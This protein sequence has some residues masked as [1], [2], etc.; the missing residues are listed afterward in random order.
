MSC[1]VDTKCFDVQL[2]L[3]LL[4]DNFQ[5]Y[6][7]SARTKAGKILNNVVTHLKIT[8]PQYFGVKVQDRMLNWVIHS[9]M[10]PTDS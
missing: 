3:T 7:I 5:F 10:T 2:K 9:E 1:D 4:D 8:H 6:S